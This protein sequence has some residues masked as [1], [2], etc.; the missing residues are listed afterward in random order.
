MK[1][2]LFL[3]K[4]K[5]LFICFLLIPFVFFGQSTIATYQFQDNLQADEAGKPPLKYYSSANVQITPPNGPVKYVNQY[6][7]FGGS[8]MLETNDN[9]SY[10]EVT[11]N[12]TGLNNINIS[13]TGEM[14]E[15]FFGSRET[16]RL[17]LF[18]DY[19]GTGSSLIL[20]SILTAGFW[21]FT[22]LIRRMSRYPQWQ[23]IIPIY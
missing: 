5:C 19:T 14:L 7:F 9:G 23:I 10:V 20:I 22:M 4:S 8:R 1:T 15:S 17:S 21:V 13:F 11:L 2:I 12:T 18:V 3:V 6:A 16:G